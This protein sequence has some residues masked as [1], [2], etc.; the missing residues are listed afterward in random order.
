MSTGTLL[1]AG[2]TVRDKARVNIRHRNSF[3]KSSE[4]STK[5]PSCDK[6]GKELVVW[7]LWFECGISPLAQIVDY[8][9]PSW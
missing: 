1:P 8:A 9:V 3:L 7:L 5:E 4:L 2:G 6:D